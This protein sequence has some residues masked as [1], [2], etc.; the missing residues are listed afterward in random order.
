M[1][2][3]IS[4]APLTALEVAPPEFV[5]TAAA[6]GYSHVGLRLVAATTTEPQYPMVGDTPMVR[7]TRARL[8]ATGIRLLDVEILRLRPDTRV[9]DF[10]PAI[11]TGA[12][13]GAS[14]VLVAG[15]DPDEARLADRYAELCDL[16]APCGVSPQL[17]FMSWSHAKDLAQAARI[18]AR[19]GRGQGGI[20]VDAFHFHRSGSRLEDIARVPPSRFRYAQLC[21]AP[22]AI[23]PTQDAI[24]A[25]ARAE[26][27]FPG[28]GELDLVPLVRALPADLPLSLEVPTLELAKSVGA[29]DRARRALCGAR[30]VLARAAERDAAAST[31]E[32]SGNERE[33][34]TRGP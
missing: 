27:R 16:A 5:S 30:A 12:R 14:Y 26:R 4:L 8:D 18:V 15:D 25:Q 31:G 22:L 29:L 34:A 28:E 24:L 2:R 6:A 19:A 20:V 1:N 33:A 23:P 7:E 32:A 3:P 11:E 9:A 10:L 17:E 13:L 21:D